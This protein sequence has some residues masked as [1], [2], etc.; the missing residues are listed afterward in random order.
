MNPGLPVEIGLLLY[1]GVLRSAVLGLTDL[2][3][4]GNRFVEPGSGGPIRVSHWQQESAG[5]PIAR[6]FD[7]APGL[8]GS[9]DMLVIPPSLEE[10]VPIA[11]AARFAE[12]LRQHHRAGGALASVCAGAFVLAESGLLD[13]RT[14]TT[15]WNYEELFQQRFPKVSLDIDRL[16]IDDG[17]IM[18]AGGVMAWTDLGLKLLD[19]FLGPGVMI[20]TA[21]TLLVDPPGREQRY[22]SVFSP[23]LMHGDR[24]ILKVQHWLQATEA[25]EIALDRLADIAGLQARTFQRRFQK[26]TGMTTSEYCQRLRVGRAQDLLRFSRQSV[27]S[28]AWDVGYKDPGAFRKIFVRVVGLSPGEYRVRFA[29]E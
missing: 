8:S 12:W 1:P 17:D 29:P 21:R 19:R 23:R 24:A 10:P 9:P 20:K 16:I 13:G 27:E 28:V 6:C 4:I 15:H 5:A 7:T 22:Y 18:T 11:T 2:F 25:Q 14:V 3:E 26:A